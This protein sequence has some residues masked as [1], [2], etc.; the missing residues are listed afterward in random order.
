LGLLLFLWSVWRRNQEGS[1]FS[2][3]FSLTALVIFWLPLPDTPKVY[4]PNLL[5]ILILLGQQCVAKR[6][7]EKFRL[8]ASAHAAMIILGG[9]GLWRLLSLWIEQQATG[10]YS[11]QPAGRAALALVFFA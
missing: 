8:E 9:L 5:A 1:L 6:L 4:L 10:P 3:A 11:Y 2:A 7:P